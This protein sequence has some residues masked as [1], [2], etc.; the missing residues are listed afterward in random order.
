MKYRLEELVDL[1]IGRTPPRKEFEWFNTNGEG[2]KWVSIKDMGNSGRFISDTSEYLTEAA[3]K[4]FGI[5]IVEKGTLLLS[6][7]L[8]VGRLCITTD[9]MLT[10]EAIAQLPIKDTN[11]VDRDFLY[12]YLKNYNFHQL[13][14]TSSIVTA[15]NSTYHKKMEIDLPPIDQQRAIAAVLSS[16]DDKIESNNAINN[17]LAA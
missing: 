15:I 3:Q 13:G 5:P 14:S 1:Q 10:N 9:R 4:R 2:Y 16:I 12:Y 8:T 11:I 6:F 7:K 17:N